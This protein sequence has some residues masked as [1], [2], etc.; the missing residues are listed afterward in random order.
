MYS[1]G[2]IAKKFKLS[3][4]TLLYYESIGLLASS[5]RTKSNYREYSEDEAQ[6][7]EQIC[8]YRETGL[9]LETIKKIL[10][11]TRN[12]AAM[13]LEKRIYELNDEIKDL[14]EQQKVAIRLL[15]NSQMHY[16]TE[17][18][19]RLAW[20]QLFH[21]AGFGDYDQWCWHRDFE[22]TNPDSHQLFLEKV[23]FS[24]DEIT[25]VRTWVHEDYQETTK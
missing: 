25:R 16:T 9:P 17:P 14:R 7:L 5:G 20:V 21:D 10:L 2:Q 13:L 3:R 19:D 18:I 23:G 4:S 11:G 1:I 22:M 8:A 24:A 15:L 6:H 12:T